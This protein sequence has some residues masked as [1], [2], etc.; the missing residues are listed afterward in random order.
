MSQIEGRSFLPT[1]LPVMGCGLPLGSGQYVSGSRGSLWWKAG[2]G[3]NSPVSSQRVTLLEEGGMHVSMQKGAG[4][5]LPPLESPVMVFIFT[6]ESSS[7]LGTV[8]REQPSF[9]RKHTRRKCLDGLQPLQLRLISEPASRSS[10]SSPTTPSR[11]PLLA[12][13]LG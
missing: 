11:S 6:Y 10:S 7:R 2:P 12:T 1:F 4:R 9:L 13:L 5:C 8:L 3:R